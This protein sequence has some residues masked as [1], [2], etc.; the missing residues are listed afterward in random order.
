MAVDNAFKDAVKANKRTQVVVTLKNSVLLDPSL[1]TFDE[2]LQYAEKRMPN[3]FEEHDGKNFKAKNEWSD[4]Y[5]YEVLADLNFNFSKERVAH[6]YELVPVVK[7]DTIKEQEA[8]K[9]ASS[10]EKI[11]LDQKTVGTG[12]AI[13]GGIATV[14]GLVTAHTALTI[15]GACVTVAGAVVALLDEE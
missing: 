12:T 9:K 13:V 4:E 11:K 3:L 2:E 1:K 14:A 5:L 8:T 10:N 15:G 7:A 6:L